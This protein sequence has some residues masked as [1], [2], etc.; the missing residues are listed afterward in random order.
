MLKSTQSYAMRIKMPQKWMEK[1]VKKT[2]P[3]LINE[4]ILKK[5][6]ICYS[7]WN[8]LC[9]RSGISKPKQKALIYGKPAGLM[10]ELFIE[11]G[12]KKNSKRIPPLQVII[13]NKRT[14]MPSKGFTY[15][16]NEYK[17]KQKMTIGDIQKDVYKFDWK[18]F[19]RKNK[20]LFL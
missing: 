2:L 10:G 20:N 11:L 14:R 19:L 13:I 3:I 7:E 18:T 9:K 5:T 4:Y 1:V 8:E 6:P 12:R 16:E 15:Y 17:G